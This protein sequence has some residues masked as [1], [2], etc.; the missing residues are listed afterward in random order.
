MTRPTKEHRRSMETKDQEQPFQLTLKA[1]RTN[2]RQKEAQAEVPNKIVVEAIL[3][4][5]LSH[6]VQ[7]LRAAIL[8]RFAVQYP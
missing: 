1:P 7:L 2:E 4:K 5:L 6:E 3:L 8:L